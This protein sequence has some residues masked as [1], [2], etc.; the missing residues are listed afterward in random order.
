MKWCPV[1]HQHYEEH[2]ELCADCPETPLAS[3][4]APP[5]VR[6]SS[7]A[8]LPDEPESPVLEELLAALFE[9]RLASLAESE[10]VAFCGSC[11][12]EVPYGVPECPECGT[13]IWY[14]ES[15]GNDDE[16]GDLRLSE[17]GWVRVLHADR[18]KLETLAAMLVSEG[19]QVR[20]EPIGQGLAA[21]HNLGV[22]AGGDGTNPGAMMCALDVHVDHLEQTDELLAQ[23]LSDPA[24][25]RFDTAHLD[26][27][28]LEDVELAEM[29]V[30][31]LGQLG[32]EA[33]RIHDGERAV[34]LVPGDVAELVRELLEE[35]GEAFEYE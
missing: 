22:L 6:A 13:E 10:E 8:S 4:D 33:D 7:A 28:E 27:V 18:H 29:L 34:L 9:A 1:C 12:F 3:G 35:F 17:R 26:R 21:T 31:Q 32:V 30:A 24:D 15:E 16:L 19:L 11:A 2:V 14:E 25:Q 20:V 5:P 23:V